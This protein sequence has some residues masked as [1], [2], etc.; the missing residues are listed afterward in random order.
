MSE[1]TRP[2]KRV[3]A[4]LA[5]P[6]AE[7]LEQLRAERSKELGRFVSISEVIEQLLADQWSAKP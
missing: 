6:V 1:N 3:P 2:Y 5:E 7:R 4:Q